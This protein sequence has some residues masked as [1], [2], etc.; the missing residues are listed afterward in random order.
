[1]PI[2]CPDEKLARIIER[3]PSNMNSAESQDEADKFVRV[4]VEGSEFEID[5]AV[6]RV[7]MVNKLAKTALCI[8]VDD[9]PVEAMFHFRRI[10]PLIIERTT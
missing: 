10:A 7:K 8:S 2:N 5:H 3:L 4:V 9:E 1:M 6:F